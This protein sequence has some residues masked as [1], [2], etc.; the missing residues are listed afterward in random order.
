MLDTTAAPSTDEPLDKLTWVFTATTGG[1]L[2]AFEFD[3]ATGELTKKGEQSVDSGSK[4]DVF[5]AM[6]RGSTR[7]F[8]VINKAIV[9]Y[10]FDPAT[11]SF[12]EE[13]R[14]TTAGG[15]TYVS[16]AADL[17]HVYVAHYNENALSYLTYRN[18][19]F[20]PHQEFAAGQKVHSAQ[21][22][23]E[24]DWVLVPCLGSDHVAQYRRNGDSLTAAATATV[25]VPGGPRHFAFNP[26]KPV[27]YLLTE[28]TGE[29]RAFEFS[30]T[31]GL[32]AALDTEVIGVQ[33]GG[34]YW[35]SDVKVTPDG[36]DVFAVERNAKKVY[37]FDVEED[38]LLHPSGVS[39]DLGG[40]VRA[41]DVSA[42]GKYLFMG[43]SNQE[44]RVL[45]FESTTNELTTL[46]NPI[47]GLGEVYATLVR[48]F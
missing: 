22:S 23:V 35:G 34:K 31:Q 17:E 5:I 25:A 30:T 18:G 43:N 7:L 29:L 41:F 2:R 16:V 26:T 4:Q 9:V 38:G 33:S 6:A 3:V 19:E 27:V 8:V 1:P 39:V 24:G 14:G 13:A 15:G 48:E 45:S 42:D 36:Q 46:P 37:H 10:D 11:G 40:V 20:S 32:G 47:G 21:E 44:L 12:T 28:L